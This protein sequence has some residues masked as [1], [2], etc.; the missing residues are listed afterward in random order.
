MYWA[1]LEEK[2]EHTN[3]SLGISNIREPKNMQAILDLGI[4]YSETEKS[5]ARNTK[6]FSVVILFS[7]FFCNI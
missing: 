2:I 5:I 3:G 1:S 6:I 4:K 7:L